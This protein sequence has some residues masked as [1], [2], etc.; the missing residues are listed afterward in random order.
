M[1]SLYMTQS[2]ATHCTL[3]K[4]L[5]LRLVLVLTEGWNPGDIRRAQRQSQAA[6]EAP[7]SNQPGPS[8]ENQD[9]GTARDRGYSPE[10]SL[11]SSATS[12]PNGQRRMCRRDYTNSVYGEMFRM[13]RQI[14]STYQL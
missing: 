14:Q 10:S 2:L 1:T 4:K 13:A 3:V 6:L 11:Q 8:L 12:R 9:N 7:S 5:G